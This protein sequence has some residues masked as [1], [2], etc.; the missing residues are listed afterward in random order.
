MKKLSLNLDVLSVESFEVAQ[1]QAEKGTVNGHLFAP[2]NNQ[3]R[4]ACCPDTYQV[5]CA[6]TCTCP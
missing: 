2:S 6:A 5:S 3:P 1:E 4:T